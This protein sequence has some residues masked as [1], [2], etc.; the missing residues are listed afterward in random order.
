MEEEE[1]EEEEELV[2]K[3]G[4]LVNISTWDFPNSNEGTPLLRNSGFFKKQ[5]MNP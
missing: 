1:E 4:I 3:P 2:V 5:A